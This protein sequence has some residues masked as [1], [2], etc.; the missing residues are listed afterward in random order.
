MAA[1]CAMIAQNAAATRCAASNHRPRLSGRGFVL[2]EIHNT[3]ETYSDIRM[4]K[5]GIEQE[6]HLQARLG[7][8]VTAHS[9]KETSIMSITV[10]NVLMCLSALAAFACST[11]LAW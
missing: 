9:R 11:H 6:E 8:E 5:G 10:R 7:R 2:P 3:L 4:M 1:L